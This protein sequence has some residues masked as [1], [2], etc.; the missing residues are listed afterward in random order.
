MTGYYKRFWQ[1]QNAKIA[2]LIRRLLIPIANTI[3]KHVSAQTELSDYANIADGTVLN[4]ANVWFRETQ[5]ALAPS[6]RRPL[7]E[8]DGASTIHT[9]VADIIKN[10][11]ERINEYFEN[12]LCEDIKTLAR[13][14]RDYDIDLLIVSGKPSEMPCVKKLIETYVPLP[15]SRCIS[16]KGLTVGAWYPFRD[17]NDK[18]ADAKNVNI[19]G[20]ALSSLVRYH[21][22]TSIDISEK[23]SESGA[24]NGNK[25][26]HTNNELNR[27]IKSTSNSNELF[28]AGSASATV[29]F[30]DCDRIC[31]Y[32]TA[33]QHISTYSPVYQFHGLK[34]TNGVPLS[35][36]YTA[37][38]KLEPN[39]E[40]SMNRSSLRR[41]D[42]KALS[43][44]EKE[45]IEFRLTMMASDDYWMEKPDLQIAL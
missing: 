38:L 6:E 10:K 18:I 15:E 13:H 39:G 37:E 44:E 7:F 32:Y 16:V 31:R 21:H 43:A 26:A 20:L 42:G 29:V 17:N 3:L 27:L 28:P 41:K 36:S 23:P 4:S 45:E 24:A 11:S 25:W 9:V 40:I 30:N 35:V 5:N 19:V 22:V 34:D 33:E 1:Q 12:T 2:Y 14:V 8:D